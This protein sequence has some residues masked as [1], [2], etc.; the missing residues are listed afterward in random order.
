MK[1]REKY[2]NW[3]I[4][5]CSKANFESRFFLLQAEN[6]YSDNDLENA[7]MFYEKA[8]F[9]ARKYRSISDEAYGCELAG[10]FFLEQGNVKASLEYFTMAQQKF[11]EWGA[12]KK[13]KSL[14]ET[15][16]AQSRSLGER[17][18]QP[19]LMVRGDNSKFQSERGY[20]LSKNFSLPEDTSVE[21]PNAEEKE[22]L[23]QT[24]AKRWL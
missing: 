4:V 21:D 16:Q 22:D 8:I 10:Y 20:F 11:F 7:K 24:F 3:L 13:A 6:Y 12:F 19:S 23:L 1:S 15:I 14:N 2:F 18:K 17:Y 5:D 9:S